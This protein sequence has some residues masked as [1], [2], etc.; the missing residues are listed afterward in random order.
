MGL[1]LA[2]V[3][4]GQ[5]FYLNLLYAGLQ[6]AGDPDARV[7]SMGSQC[8]RRAAGLRPK[9]GATTTGGLR[10]QTG[11]SRICPTPEGQIP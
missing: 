9:K 1:D 6:V 3:H 4:P 2:Y 11:K 10:A 8:N 5:P 7:L